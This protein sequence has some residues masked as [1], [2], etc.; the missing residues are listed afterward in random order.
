VELYEFDELLGRWGDTTKRETI[1]QDNSPEPSEDHDDDEHVPG[2]IDATASDNPIPS[3]AT[4]VPKSEQTKKTYPL[5]L[6]HL[7]NS[8]FKYN[9]ALALTEDDPVFVNCGDACLQCCLQQAINFKE[10]GWRQSYARWIIN[11]VKNPERQV[12]NPRLHVTSIG[13]KGMLETRK[14]RRIESSSGPQE[15]AMELDE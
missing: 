10:T 3:A 5:R 15:G 2:N 6:S 4:K 9:T 14:K 13:R 11:K 1:S 8:F 12:P 7:L